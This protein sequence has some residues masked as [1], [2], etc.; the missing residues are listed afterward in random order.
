MVMVH[1]SVDVHLRYLRRSSSAFG[2]RI[3]VPPAVPSPGQQQ[4]TPTTTDDVPN[5]HD[6]DYDEILKHIGQLGK[7]QITTFLMLC[8]PA[9]APG[10]A[11]MSYIF[12]GVVPDYRYLSKMI[13]LRINHYID[14]NLRQMLRTGLRRSQSNVCY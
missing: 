2:A 9:M 10:V 13:F 14:E 6:Y 8:L 3:A 5:L 11:D 1:N 12:T 4:T 7:S